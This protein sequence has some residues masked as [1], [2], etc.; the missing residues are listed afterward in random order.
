[1]FFCHLVPSSFMHNYLGPTFFY[2]YICRHCISTC[3]LCSVNK[4]S[5]PNLPLP[6]P[7][8]SLESL[9]LMKPTLSEVYYANNTT[10]DAVGGLPSRGI[11]GGSITFR[12]YPLTNRAFSLTLT[13]RSHDRYV[14]SV[15]T[16]FAVLEKGGG[17]S[18]RVTYTDSTCTSQKESRIIL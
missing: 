5:L 16:A 11:C 7:S 15:K 13:G 4:P 1:M 17:Q 2:F 6:S 10:P 18:R 3:Q 9:S 14:F 12:A 8:L